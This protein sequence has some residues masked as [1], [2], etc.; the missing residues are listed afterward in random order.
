[1]LKSGLLEVDHPVVHALNNSM[2]RHYLGYLYH[3][4][5]HY[6]KVN[7][8]YEAIIMGILVALFHKMDLEILIGTYFSSHPEAN[9]IKICGIDWNTRTGEFHF[10]SNLHKTVVWHLANI[11]RK[12]IEAEQ[13]THPNYFNNCLTVDE[14]NNAAKFIEHIPSLDIKDEIVPRDKD[15]PIMQIN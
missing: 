4:V 2:Y 11:S 13:I 8:E 5:S 12:K 10:G 14:L 6:H 9:Q 1:M 7:P 15:S 3:E